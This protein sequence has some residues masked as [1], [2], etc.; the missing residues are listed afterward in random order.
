MRI[1]ELIKNIGVLS[2]GGLCTKAISFF[3][4]PLYTALIS[5]EDYG[6][7]DYLTTVSTLLI[8]I[9]SFQ[10]YE[11][12][13]KFATVQRGNVNEVKVIFSNIW[14]ISICLCFIFSILYLSCIGIFD[15]VGKWYV[16]GA[17]VAN[18]FLNVV[19]KS[20]RSLGHNVLYSL[21]NVISAVVTIT[22]NLL[23]LVV[24]KLPALYMLY[25]YIAGPLIGG[26][27]CV[28]SDRLW[29]YFDIRLLS[30]VKI[31]EY[32][33]YS[34]PLIPNEIAWWIIHA[35]DRLV[36]VT[37]LG[38]YYAGIL[39]VA[40]KFSMAYL[41]AFSFFYAAW[42]EQCFLHYQTKTG[43][44]YIERLIPKIFLVFCYSTVVLMVICI[45]LYPIVI[46]FSYAEGIILLPWYFIAVLL[47]VIV[48]LVSPIYLIQ[49]ET[50]T[51]MYSTI[52]AGAINI[53]VNLISIG[54]LGVLSAPIS[55]ICGYG[56]VALWRWFDVK[57]RYLNLN[58][59][60]LKMV[61]ASLLLLLSAC[62]YLFDFKGYDCL[63]SVAVFVWIGF[64]CIREYYSWRKSIQ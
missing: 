34:Y 59:S 36:I 38:L 24:F 12:I 22:L 53:V 26:M 13:F 62:L 56:S 20:S 44:E 60:V 17:V 10:M 4:I 11:A 30:V 58:I 19:S 1:L 16:I 35:S 48:G 31:K 15:F 46:N 25:A 9:V 49:N 52:T 50:K 37:F 6:T 7:I 42:V 57:N 61:E 40:T 54:V 39:A 47:N 5:V 43:K 55:A 23:F 14:F 18:I 27:V 32:I 28:F 33:R 2:I 51:V 3:L 45:Y 29:T 21:V 64:I 41:T 8:A 63:V